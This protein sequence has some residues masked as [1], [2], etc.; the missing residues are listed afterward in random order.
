MRED[1]HA[2]KVAGEARQFR[3]P[4]SPLQEEVNQVLKACTWLLIPLAAILIF[5]LIARSTPL[6]EAAQEATAGLITLIPEGLVLLMSVTLAV[7]AIRLAR[8]EHAGAA[9]GGDRVARGRGHDLRRQDGHPD[10]GRAEAGRRRGSRT[11][12]RA[13]AAAEGAGALRRQLGRAQPHPGGDR[14]ALPR[15]RRARLGRGPLLLGVEVERADAGRQPRRDL[16]ARGPRRDDGPRRAVAARA[17][18]E[19]P[20]RRTRARGAG[21]SSSAAPRAGCPPTPR[22]TRCRRSRRWR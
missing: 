21:W 7:A 17:P 4:P 5:A 9:D 14:P 13:S 22:A 1:S 19:E 16:R 6:D 12:A 15:Q 18:A 8:L 10:H 11:T 20:S 2:A 3:H